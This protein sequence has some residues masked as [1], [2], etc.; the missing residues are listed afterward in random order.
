MQTERTI[1]AGHIPTVRTMMEESE[2]KRPRKKDG[3]KLMN[4]L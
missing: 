1:S 2:E 3:R 4:D